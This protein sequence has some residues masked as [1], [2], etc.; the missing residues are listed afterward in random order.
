MKR[1]LKA[2][3]PKVNLITIIAVYLL[4]LVGG[5]V[6]STGSGMGC[7]DWPKCFG[8]YIPPTD[9][10]QLPP[11][12]K[13]IYSDKRYQKN[14]KV[15]DMAEAIGFRDLANSLRTDKSMKEEADFNATKTWIEYINRLIGALIGLFILFNLITAWGYWPENKLIFGSAFITFLMVGFQGWIGSIVVSTNLLPGIITFHMLLAL[16]IVAL[17]IFGQFAIE[18]R[19]S[20]IRFNSPKVLS[21]LLLIAIVLYLGQI[22]LGTQVRESIDEVAKALT[23]IN[24][25]EWVEALGLEFYIHRSYSIIILGLHI[26]I[27]Y[28]V[29]KT[30]SLKVFGLDLF[31]V[32]V[33][34][35]VFE[36]ATGAGMAYFSIP[37]FL[38]PIHLL[39]ASLIFGLQFYLYCVVAL[40]KQKAIGKEIVL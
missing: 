29:R 4:I 36:I 21:N 11:N 31:S 8:E 40:R 3:Y 5:I 33:Y 26:Y 30:S 12:Y 7:P 6:R 25:S 16:A 23:E 1:K 37:A 39:V 17:L 38:Q 20:E 10:S 28:L 19:A 35:I 2:L 14:L 34:L 24:R 18:G 32:L 9:V 27:A 13:D 22:A 15:A